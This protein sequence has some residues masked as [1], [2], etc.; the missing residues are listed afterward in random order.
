MDKAAGYI[1]TAD[2]ARFPLRCRANT[3]DLDSFAQIFVERMF[4]C[5]D[6]V[7]VG[8][9]LIIDCGAYVGYSAA[10]F[11]S[12]FPQCRLIAVEPEPSNFQMLE[13]NMFPYGSSVEL[14]NSA[15]WPEVTELTLTERHGPGR[16]WS[17]QV[18]PYRSGDAFSFR[19][20]DIGTLLRRSGYDR[21]AILKIDIEGSENLIFSR[22][23]GEWIDRV[24]NIV[25]ELHG[26][27]V[28]KN[29]HSIFYQAIH[30]KGFAVSQAGELTVCKRS[31]P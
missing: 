3:S 26:E 21:V 23:Y 22:N 2:C 18:R 28:Q 8:T 13:L 4:K 14:I 1:V 7:V 25:I 29:C 11:L 31:A 30:D 15:V 12:R 24:D 16:E 19:A 9:G 20:V 5:L 10:Y 6:S 17:R 27:T